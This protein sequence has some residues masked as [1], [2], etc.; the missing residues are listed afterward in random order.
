MMTTEER[1][2]YMAGQ[3]LRNFAPKGED[4][5]IA[6]TLDHLTQFWDPRMKAQAIALLDAEPNAVTGPVRTVFERL[7]G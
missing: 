7:R 5:A 6:A 3:I 2:A 4:A 1:L